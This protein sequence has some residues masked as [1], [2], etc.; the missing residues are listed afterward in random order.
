MKE[1]YL[2]ELLNYKVQL[3]NNPEFIETDPVSIPH[4]FSKKEDIEIAGFL[5]ASIAWGNR[6]VIIKNAA[7]LMQLMDNSPYEFVINF[8][9]EDLRQF[10][11]FKHRTFQFPDLQFFLTALQDI[12]RNLGGLEAVF[13]RYPDDI[14]LSLDYFRKIF[15]Q[16]AHLPRSEKHLSSP[17]KGSA[18]KRLNMFLRWMVRKDNKQVDFGIWKQIPMSALKLPLDVHSGNVA[19]KL[20]LLSRKQNDWKAVEEVT[21]NLA[22][23]NPEDPVIYDYALFGMGVFEKTGF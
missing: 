7:R 9:P 5:T 1:S 10:E 16:T 20:G 2:E 21:G 13:S 22:Q 18:C 14:K 23:F 8:E 11:N 15:L 12:Y 17:L 6:S 4:S 3:Y 19:R